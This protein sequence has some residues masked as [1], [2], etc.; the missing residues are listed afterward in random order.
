MAARTLV[1]FSI[2]LPGSEGN[3][4]RYFTLK[5]VIGTDS[6]NSIRNII[7]SYKVTDYVFNN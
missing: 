3:V 6:K 7:E 2:C 1:C 4:N 5:K